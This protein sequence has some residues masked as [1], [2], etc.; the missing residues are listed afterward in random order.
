M[1][2]MVGVD[3]LCDRIG[4]NSMQHDG[5][6]MRHLLVQLHYVTMPAAIV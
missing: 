1:Q 4:C 6:E 2:K 3:M 5:F